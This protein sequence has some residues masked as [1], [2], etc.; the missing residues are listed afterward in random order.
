MDTD[1]AGT[2]TYDSFGLLFGKIG[3]DKCESS[4]FLPC[5][6]LRVRNDSQKGK[7]KRDNKRKG[8]RKLPSCFGVCLLMRFP[9]RHAQESH[10]EGA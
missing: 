3:S 2:T 8:K 1:E 7:S 5:D 6:K 10:G 4:R 9:V